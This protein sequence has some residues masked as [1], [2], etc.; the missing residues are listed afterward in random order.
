M[1]KMK[2]IF[3]GLAAAAVAC[4]A[5]VMTASAAVFTKTGN[6]DDTPKVYNVPTDGLDL[7]KLDKIVANLTVDSG[8]VSGCIGYSDAN[9][10]WAQ[11]AQT[12]SATSGQWVVSN[13][14]GNVSGGIQIQFWWVN[15]FYD[16]EG[17]EGD[18]G[19]ATVESVQ[20]LD[21]NGNPIGAVQPAEETQPAVTD[22]AEGGTTETE[23]SAT[24][25]NAE[26]NNPAVTT[27][28]DREATAPTNGTTTAANAN[29]T[30]ISSTT[31]SG[32]NA[33][34]G[35]AANSNKTT[36]AAPAKN[37]TKTT[38]TDNVKT[39]DAGVGV[40]VAAMMLAA[41][42]AYAARKKH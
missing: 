2:R 22:P 39:G 38:T 31:A 27:T 30:D 5:T 18:P 15:P 19:T 24:E 20:L 41:A 33:A 16:A 35:T 9:T 32:S 28:L 13:L 4:A 42:T 6:G 29:G 21:A 8:K 23:V 12:L 10:D 36:T 3:A 37:D 34:S 26:T 14:G 25:T 7:S 1:M 11:S 17:N 40:A